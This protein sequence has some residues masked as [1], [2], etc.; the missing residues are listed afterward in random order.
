MEITITCNTELA[1][2]EGFVYVDNYAGPKDFHWLV[3]SEDYSV[4]NLDESVPVWLVHLLF[5]KFSKSRTLKLN[6]KKILDIKII[7]E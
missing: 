7:T 1:G 3:W 6:G 5:W 4:I 2:A